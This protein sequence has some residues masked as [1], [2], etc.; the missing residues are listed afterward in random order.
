MKAVLFGI[1]TILCIGKT[2][3]GQVQH[4]LECGL[5]LIEGGIVKQR[6]LDNRATVH[7]NAIEALQQRRTITWIPV[8]IRNVG[9]D[10]GNGYT[11]ELS[12]YAMFCDLN[13]DYASQNIQ[14]Y[15][16]SPITYLDLQSIHD[17]AFSN[18]AKMAMR[19]NKVPNT[20]NIYVGRSVNNPRASFYSGGINDFVFMLNAQVSATTNTC[21]HEIGHFFTLPHTFYGWENKDYQA[22]Y[23]GTKAPVYIGG[24]LVEYEARTGPT[25]NCNTAADGFCDTPADYYTTRESCPYS[26]TGLVARDPDSIIISPSD[27]NLMSYFAYVCR[28]T[29]TNDQ[30]NAVLADIISRNWTNFSAPASTATSLSGAQFSPISPLAGQTIAASG[31]F[32]TLSWNP[33]PGAT[34]YYLEI[35]NTI[36]GIAA[37]TT[38]PIAKLTV[39]GTSYNILVNSLNL[40]ST[41][42]WRIK[43]LNDYY[44]CSDLSTFYMFKF[45]QLTNLQKLT[46]NQS[47]VE[48]AIYPNPASASEITVEVAA[49]NIENG[50]FKLL[51]VDG[52]VLETYPASSIQEGVNQF[53]LNVASLTRGTYILALSTSTGVYHKKFLIL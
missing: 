27:S 53:K 23:G 3:Q 32:V 39:S 41:Y 31:G 52:R 42:A 17:N 16:N 5:D 37:N 34:S 44:T 30:Q 33:V 14:F 8:T 4:S 1:L 10:N 2:L 24:K 18:G 51:A 35:F 12:I 46:D 26:A 9:D 19:N 48:L 36:G 43:P 25:A 49:A 20:L 7:P 22:L 11:S 28:R 47:K 50:T 6:M 45:G 38:S 15:L 21:S 40:N 13:N 29:F